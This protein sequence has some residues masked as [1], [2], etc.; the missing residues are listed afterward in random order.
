M[1]KKLF[2][3]GF[4][5]LIL[6]G[7]NTLF[8]SDFLKSEPE[9]RTSASYITS[10]ST[11]NDPIQAY[12]FP[13]TEPAYI[14]ILDSNIPR[15]EIGAKAAMV[16]NLRSSRFLFQH[17]VRQELP[18]ASLTK[19]L[20][21]AVVLDKINQDDIVT[22]SPSSV[23]VDGSKQDL[24]AGEKLTANNL[25]RMML[26]SSSND[27]ASALAEYAE[28]QGFDFVDAM[29]V[30]ARLIGMTDSHFLDPAG[31]DDAATS[32]AY[33]VVKLVRAT[34]SDRRIW[35]TLVE[36]EVQISSIDGKITHIIKNTDELLGVI[37]DII[38]GKTGYTD[39]ALGCLILLVNIPEYDDTIVSVVLGS[40]DRFG[41][42]KK[43][44]D[45]VKAAYRWK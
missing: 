5:I 41:D 3:I 44:I 8:I 38:G 18:I 30:R 20:T 1:A 36:K 35:A 24:Y 19:V 33:D 42:S 32:T 9:V 27:A 39:G 37:P 14:P 22:V 25:L 40:Q 43:I 31:L 21:A 10:A 12:L 2:I 28:Q 11:N 4:L 34:L 7:I 23:R 16:F 6:V 13:I 29:N 26:I 45:W 17:N 15:P